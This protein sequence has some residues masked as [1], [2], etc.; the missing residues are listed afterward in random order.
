MYNSPYFI[1]GY[2]AKV[3]VFNFM[4]GVVPL[5]NSLHSFGVMNRIG[6]G[7]SWFKNLNWG[8]IINGASKTLGFV[9]QTIPL[10]RQVGPMF[11]NMRSM[12]KILSLFR[13]ETIP[14]KSVIN[15]SSQE[16]SSAIDDRDYNDNGPTFFTY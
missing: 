5:S 8:G 1:P 14:K 11:N 6:N 10:V 2:Y 7:F 15:N 9:N 3:P 16:K 4:R 13:E 12:I